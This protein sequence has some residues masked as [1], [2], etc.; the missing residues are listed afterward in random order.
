MHVIIYKNDTGDIVQVFTNSNVQPKHIPNGCS[1]I[2]TDT[3]PSKFLDLG[4]D[5][6]KVVNNAIVPIE[7]NDSLDNLKQKKFATIDAKT[8]EIIA[9][10]FSFSGM[11]FSTSIEAQ[12][13]GLALDQM[14]NDPLLQYPVTWN[15]IDDTDAIQLTNADMVHN[16]VLSGIA[17]YRAAVDTGSALKL[18][19]RQAATVTAVLDITDTRT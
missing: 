12:A 6:F 13:R 1:Y 18:Q 3:I 19:I 16:F 8:D 15:N 2:I 17:Y 4:I 11:Q 10:G 5:F 14:R 7:N 9:R